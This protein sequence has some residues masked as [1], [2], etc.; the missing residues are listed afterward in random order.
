MCRHAHG[1]IVQLAPED[2]DWNEP[3]F[4]HGTP[5]MA[6]VNEIVRSGQL[7]CEVKAMLQFC[8]G[9]GADPRTHAPVARGFSGGWGNSTEE[10]PHVTRVFHAGR[11]AITLALGLVSVLERIS[12]YEHQGK[13]VDQLAA[14][15]ELL[16]VF[17]QFQPA[18]PSRPVPEAA[19]NMWNSVRSDQE[20]ADVELRVS[21]DPDAGG[22][23]GSDFGTV[24]MA[25]SLVLC[26][27]SPV[28]G[29]MLNSSMREGQTKVVSVPGASV[30]AVRLL[31]AIVYSGV[32]PPSPP[33][34]LLRAGPRM[35]SVGDRV[36][37]NW[38]G[39]G[40]WW[41]GE[42]S[43][44]RGDGS[45]DV[46]YCGE[47]SFVERWV[48]LACLRPAG[49]SGDC[50]SDNGGTTASHIRTQLTALDVA[51]RWQV[52]HAV[53]VLEQALA[54]ELREIRW[55][56]TTVRHHAEQMQSFELMCDAAALHELPVLRAACQRFGRESREVQGHF[57]QGGFGQTARRELRELVIDV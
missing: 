26:H 27:S 41:P 7:N 17:G 9:Q 28:L 16:T 15:K 54:C 25:H 2:F 6:T 13:Y 55:W 49:G 5:L 50:A 57:E 12:L 40:S 32:V 35:W 18:A 24:V 14:A 47:G 33:P 48:R 37:A 53:A 3:H 56:F 36:E 30:A 39:R 10:F 19:I 23:A 42:V 29:A 52:Q 4:F 46:A 8:M 20:H 21:G 45:C 1:V 43:R 22:E 11:S 34:T 38:F 51:H 44:V 31:L